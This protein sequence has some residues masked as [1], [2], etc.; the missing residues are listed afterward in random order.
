MASKKSIKELADR[1]IS[2]LDSLMPSEKADA[3]VRDA[4]EELYNDVLGVPGKII[5]DTAQPVGHMHGSFGKGKRH[6]PIAKYKFEPN[7][8]TR[9]D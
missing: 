2:T 8:P 7:E 6:L 1:L 9:T 4:A 5:V 3:I